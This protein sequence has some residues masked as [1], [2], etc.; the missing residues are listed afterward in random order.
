VRLIKIDMEIKN[1][2]HTPLKDIVTAL[3][4]AFSD[5]F[6]QMPNNIPYWENRLRIARHDPTL[7]FGM[8]DGTVLAG[9]IL[10][11]VDIHEGHLTAFNTGTGV[12][13]NYRGKNIVDKLY[14]HAIPQFKSR[15][16][17]HCS[18]EVIEA[19]HK[20]IK[21][22]ERIGFAKNSFYYCFKGEL[23]TPQENMILKKI[24][25][26]D[27]HLDKRSHLNSW[28]HTDKAI[29][30]AANYSCFEVLENE[31][32]MGYFVIDPATGY[33]PQLNIYSNKDSNWEMLLSGIATISQTI[34][35]N[36]VDSKKEDLVK[37]LL[38]RGL[39]N[40]INQYEMQ[41][42]I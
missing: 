18:L 16:I 23:K 14:E 21:V 41:M 7:S 9:F 22:Y 38:K 19:N 26:D 13:P 15:G 40:F 36:N 20:A 11:G 3:V 37:A 25:F 35:I 30:L 34:K 42:S 2:E 12:L 4:E 39:D 8:F 31:K 1:L 29:Q 28:D 5:Y 24:D 32:A 33:I 6:V 10:I 17:T 27:V